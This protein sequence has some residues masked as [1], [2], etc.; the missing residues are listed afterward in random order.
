MPKYLANPLRQP[1]NKRAPPSLLFRRK[2]LLFAQQGGREALF[3]PSFFTFRKASLPFKHFISCCPSLL[4]PSFLRPS[5][6]EWGGG[7]G[8]G[9]KEALTISEMETLS[10]FSPLRRPWYGIQQ[11]YYDFLQ[12]LEWFLKLLELD[13]KYRSNFICSFLWAN[14]LLFILLAEK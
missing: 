5:D 13:R 6:R 7:G 4:S 11:S 3:I 12:E 10:F 14:Y 2:S 8:G 9:K 1:R